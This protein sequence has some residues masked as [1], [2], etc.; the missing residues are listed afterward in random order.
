M[1]IFH[2]QNSGPQGHVNLKFQISGATCKISDPT[3]QIY[4]VHHWGVFGGYLGGIWGGIERVLGGSGGVF[5]GYL[6][7]CCI[8]NLKYIISKLRCN[9]STFVFMIWSS[10]AA[11]KISKVS[12]ESSSGVS[13]ISNASFVHSFSWPEVQVMC[14]ESQ[15]HYLK[16][17]L[18]NMKFK[19]CTWNLKCGI[20][21]FI[22]V[23]W[24][25][26]G[27]SEISNASFKGSSSLFES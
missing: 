10:G 19:G 9:I 7:V 1:L 14:L 26:G 15:I 11:P 16:V 18:H 8:W 12:F 5:K 13:D 25:S 6:R 17:H 2:V 27:V 4:T 21:K 20:W 24:S 23:I 22:S 3:I